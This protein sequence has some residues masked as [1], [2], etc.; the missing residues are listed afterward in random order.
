MKN[1]IILSLLCF[2]IIGNL[3]AL[4]NENAQGSDSMNIK[5]DILKSSVSI[6]VPDNITFEQITKGYLSERKDLNIENTGTT[7]INVIPLLEEN[8]TEGIFDHI[9]FKKTLSANLTRIGNFE[10]EIKKPTTMGG[11]KTEGIYMHLD[12]TGF[13]G[14][15]Q[16]DLIGHNT[17]IIFWAIPI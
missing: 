3:N 11:I 15:I 2:I 17:N 12:L 7:D 4:T 9:S 5:A 14:E 16:N 6:N 8:Y 1:L 13:E 10:F